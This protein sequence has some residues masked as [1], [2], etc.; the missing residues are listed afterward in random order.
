[1]A[2]HALDWI[3]RFEA[4]GALLSETPFDSARLDYDRE[5]DCLYVVFDQSLPET[6]S[7]TVIVHY[8]DDKAVGLTI[9][10]A[11][12]RATK[13][14]GK[15]PDAGDKMETRIDS[16]VNSLG[17][18]DV[19][20][21]AS[22]YGLR[23]RGGR[24]AVA[25]LFPQ[26]HKVIIAT[27]QRIASEAHLQGWDQIRANGWY[28]AEDSVRWLVPNGSSEKIGIGRQVLARLLLVS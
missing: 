2:K 17:G 27:S 10:D 19:Y 11:S 16:L 8:H 4:I 22:G 14:G 1:M 3:G 23:R 24:R 13:P 5:V 21:M 18:A 20:S 26:E 12:R 25:H 9:L 15:D 28:G 6:D 7:E